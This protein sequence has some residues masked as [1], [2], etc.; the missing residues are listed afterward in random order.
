VAET[1]HKR[2]LLWSADGTWDRLL[3]HVQAVADAIGDID[4]DI[5]IDSTS[6]RA[7]QH[8]A[9]APNTIR[10]VEPFEERQGKRSQV[11][12]TAESPRDP[13][14]IAGRQAKPSGGPV[15]G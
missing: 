9:E 7:H 12:S 5:N 6:A 13:L 11:P 4:W 10:V 14:T 8:A 2:H 15:A 3:L 1:V